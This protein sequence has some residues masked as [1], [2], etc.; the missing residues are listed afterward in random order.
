MGVWSYIGSILIF[1]ITEKSASYTNDFLTGA[2]KFPST[3]SYRNPSIRG[4]PNRFGKMLVGA[5]SRH[6]D[7]D[8]YSRGAS[9]QII[10]HIKFFRRR[11]K[12]INQHHRKKKKCSWIPKGSLR[13][14]QTMCKDVLR[15][16]RGSGLWVRTSA[17]ESCTKPIDFYDW[18]SFT[19][20]ANFL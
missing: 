15:K 18:L 12:M 11:E 4:G 20:Q 16:V 7:R 8:A 19:A 3:S 10:R 17:M 6:G 9:S 5:E 1:S 2:K 14:E 13:D